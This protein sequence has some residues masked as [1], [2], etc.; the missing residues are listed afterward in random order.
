MAR[1]PR[2]YGGSC[3]AGHRCLRPS[4]AFESTT[5][6]PVCFSRLHGMGD[7]E[8]AD[9]DA[10]V[11]ETL[12]FLTVR[13]DGDGDG[14]WVGDAPSWFG[15]VLFG[16]FV[17][18]Q[19][20]IAATTRRARRSPAAFVACVLLASGRRRG[21]DRVLGAT[22]S[23]GPLVHLA[24]RG[25]EPGFASRC[26]TCRARSPRIPTDTSTTSRCRARAPR[27]TSRRSNAARAHGLRIRRPDA[28]R[29]R[30]HA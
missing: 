19:A 10:A 16:G 24:T 26:S 18:A 9:L 5:Q 25:R 28:A 14:A 30:R 27:A 21:A 15:P 7:R 20:M 22:D 4:S 29:G 12:A 1:S 13:P 2:M 6:G 3:A 17:I 8:Q 23:R 11:A